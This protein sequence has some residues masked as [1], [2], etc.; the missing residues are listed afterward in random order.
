MADHRPG[1]G[2]IAVCA[3]VVIEYQ[4]VRHVAEADV[5]FA[6]PLSETFIGPL[7]GG[8]GAAASRAEA[9]RGNGFVELSAGQSGIRPPDLLIQ[10]EQLGAGP[11]C[12]STL[13]PVRDKAQAAHALKVH[14]FPRR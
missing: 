12:E 9:L 4:Q 11:Q 7:D 13:D 10:I 14:S 6:W 8:G 3:R 5:A 1:L 2:A